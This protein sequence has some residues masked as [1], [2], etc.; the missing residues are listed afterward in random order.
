MISIDS[1]RSNA[2]TTWYYNYTTPRLENYIS[3]CW[4]ADH[5]SWLGS[6][7]FATDTIFHM[8]NRSGDTLRIFLNAN[9]GDFWQFLKEEESKFVLAT[10]ERYEESTWLG[11]SDTLMS[12]LLSPVGYSN[13]EKQHI[14]ALGGIK[15]SSTY[16]LY[17]FPDFYEY[18]YI[19]EGFIVETSQ[20]SYSFAGQDEEASKVISMKE[21]F[22]MQ[23]GEEFHYLDEYSCIPELIE[24]IKKIHI[25]LEREY[26]PEDFRVGFTVER[27]LKRTRQYFDED[28]LP[29]PSIIDFIH[30]TVE[31]WYDLPDFRP[32]ESIVADEYE[33]RSYYVNQSSAYPD[34]QMIEVSYPLWKAEEECFDM[35]IIDGS[36]YFYYV[37][38]LGELNFSYSPFC[39]FEGGGSNKIVYFKKNEEEW[40]S[41]FSMAE[42]T[43]IDSKITDD[44]VK[45]GPQPFGD[46]LSIHLAG[47]TGEKL[48]FQL[49]DACGRLVLRR[50]LQG[51]A[52]SIPTAQLLPGFYF[53]ELRNADEKIQS[54]K[55]VKKFI[56]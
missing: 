25:I 21:A 28:M 6:E 10:V 17:A 39:Y 44:R 43:G 50:P 27:I 29:M 3:W 24:E 16:G 18:P 41:P 40:G 47:E 49:Y 33:L 8:V 2:D 52:N 53:Y 54:G 13:S 9:P 30:D 1:V 34:R 35:P 12:I 19:G 31:L 7:C 20:S 36:T 55:V 48:I 42:L 14:E 56:Y 23:P 4:K 26:I 5:A 45:I 22:D 51:D 37:E 46:F 38:G 15:I 11:R 32:H